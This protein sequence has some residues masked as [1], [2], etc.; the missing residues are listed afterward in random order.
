MA[1]RRLETPADLRKVIE[2]LPVAS[3]LTDKFEAVRAERGPARR[4]V[5]YR[6]QRQHW[7]GW[8]GGYDG[9]GA[10]AR[11]N[12]DRSAAYVYNHIVGPPMLFW[13]GEAAGVPK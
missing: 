9:P 6:S 10:Y 1:A 11:R 5:W 12:W 2:R 13:L 8:L 7:L 4:D 3:P